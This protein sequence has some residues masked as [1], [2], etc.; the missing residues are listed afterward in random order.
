MCQA[1][2]EQRWDNATMQNDA[3]ISVSE[4]NRLA[5][6]SLE[7]SLPICWVSGEVSNLS[8]ATSGHWYFTLK[9][10]QASVHCVMFRN[11]NQFVDWPLRDG[12]HVEIRAQAS[13]Y[14]TRGDFQ[15]TVEAMRQA[16][17]GSLFEA[18]LRLKTKL[19]NEGLFSTDLKKPLPAQPRIVGIVTSIQGAALHDALTTLN[20]RWPLAGV[21][22]YSASVQG[23]QAPAQIIAALQDAETLG[24]C[25]VILLIRGGGSLEDLQAFNDEGVARAISACG[26]PI[27]SG[28]GHETDFSIADFVSDHRAPTP[29]AAAEAAV[30]DQTE[31]MSRLT[32]TTQR[33]M[34]SHQRRINQLS[35]R[36]DQVC[37]ALRQPTD[38]VALLRA[39]QIHLQFRLQANVAGS[40]M[41]AREIVRATAYRLYR[42]YP[43]LSQLKVSVQH[44]TLRLLTV[45][46]SRLSQHRE[47]I[48]KTTSQLELLNPRAVLLRGY[49]LVS[50][51]AGRVV[52]NAQQL[53]PHE[54][55]Q[56]EFASGRINAEVIL[57]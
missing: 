30:P 18:F 35:Q 34:S 7:K 13:I 2:G 38:Y 50:D 10:N 52:T 4:L 12:E 5:R 40:L 23:S 3:P 48:A 49:A 8:R 54:T 51:R 33:L 42:A 31:A 44:S 6:L 28:V 47:R 32:A 27:I 9:D 45:H 25:D 14:E 22:V 21:M 57:D 46:E 56:I 37:Q 29:T 41:K 39:Q 15:L 11:R 55:V 24:C 19:E 43:S 20:R 17:Q 1:S 53:S 16:G 26:I 36:L